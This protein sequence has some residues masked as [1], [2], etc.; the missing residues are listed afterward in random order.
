MNSKE[1]CKTLKDIRKSL[2]DSLG[3]DLKQ[4]ECTFE[5]ECS[6]TCPKCKQEENILNS[7]LLK[8]GAVILGTAVLTTSLAACTPQESLSGNIQQQEP[9]TIET[10]SDIAG[11]M[12]PPSTEAPERLE[13]DVAIFE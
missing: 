6:G 11:D 5:G 8:K 13:G 7:A 4:T 3:I 10:P 2:A 9:P 12:Q 1:K